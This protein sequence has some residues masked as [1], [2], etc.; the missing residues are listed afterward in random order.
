MENEL[1]ITRDISFTNTT[2]LSSGELISTTPNDPVLVHTTF[3][4]EMKREL[5]IVCQGVLGERG[6]QLHFEDCRI[7]W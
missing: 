7:C 4:E 1:K 2:R 5:A 6:R 3:L